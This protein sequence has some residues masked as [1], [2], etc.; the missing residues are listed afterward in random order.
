MDK[1]DRA[2]AEWYL[3]EVAEEARKVENIA[4]VRRAFLKGAQYGLD[5]A[6]EILRP[7]E[8]THETE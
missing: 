8:E 2:F 5:R 4:L 1:H 6:A 7:E 3:K